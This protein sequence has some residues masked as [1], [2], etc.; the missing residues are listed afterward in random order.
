MVV[1]AVVEVGGEFVVVGYFCYVGL[2]IVDNLGYDE[3]WD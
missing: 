3:L 1:E 2:D